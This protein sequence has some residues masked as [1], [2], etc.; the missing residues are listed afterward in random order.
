MFNFVQFRAIP[1]ISEHLSA[2]Q[3]NQLRNQLETL[4]LEMNLKQSCQVLPRTAKFCKELPS[5]AKHCL[6]F[7]QKMQ[8]AVQLSMN[9]GV[10]LGIPGLKMEILR[11]LSV[12]PVILRFISTCRP[13]WI[14]KQFS[15]SPMMKTEKSTKSCFVY[16]GHYITYATFIHIY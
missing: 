8:I 2:I 7:S 1:S 16:I 3:C 12:V 9:S 6:Y 13:R 11:I 10:Y 14:F 15:K 5:T 4:N